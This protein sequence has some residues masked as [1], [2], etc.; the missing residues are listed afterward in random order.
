MHTKVV[1][2]P[3]HVDMTFYKL[4]NERE[5]DNLIERYNRNFNSRYIGPGWYYVDEFDEFSLHH[6]AIKPVWD[7]IETH[8][9]LQREHE[10]KAKQSGDLIMLLVNALRLGTEN[11]G[12]AS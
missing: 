11:D 6:Q 5:F 12:S 10:V 2:I 7:Y 9:K 8:V 1:Q 4:E 3:N